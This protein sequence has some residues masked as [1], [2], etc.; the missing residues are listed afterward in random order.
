M[1]RQQV[2][3]VEPDEPL[4]FRIGRF[5]VFIFKGATEPTHSMECR[6]S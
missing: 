6:C 5:P 2:M 3:Y 4:P 1:T